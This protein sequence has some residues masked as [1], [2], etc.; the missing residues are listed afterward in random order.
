MPISWQCTDVYG[1]IISCKTEHLD[2]TNY[3]LNF[4]VVTLHEL[5]PKVI[6]RFTLRNIRN[7]FQHSWTKLLEGE[8]LED[9]FDGLYETI[10]AHKLNIW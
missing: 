6:I 9:L 4:G 1:V 5:R 2:P 8:T 3:L 7:N 10:E